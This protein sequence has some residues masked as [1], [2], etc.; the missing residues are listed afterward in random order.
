MTVYGTSADDVFL[1]RAMADFYIP[2]LDRLHTL[3]EKIYNLGITNG[4]DDGTI[5]ASLGD[6]ITRVYTPNAVPSG[7]IDDLLDFYDNNP[8]DLAEAEDVGGRD[9]RA[10]GDPNRLRRQA[11]QRRCCARA[12]QLPPH[13]GRH[14]QHLVRRRLCRLRRYRGRLHDQRRRGQRPL[15]DRPGVQVAARQRTPRRRTSLPAMCSPP[16]KS[17]AA[18]CRTASA[19][20]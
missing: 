3:I 4:D 12:V 10:G 6:A 17:R 11:Q 20:R 7:M 9:V 18:G 19:P 2:T 8:G 5:K 14:P 1:L 16:S 15:P 13:R